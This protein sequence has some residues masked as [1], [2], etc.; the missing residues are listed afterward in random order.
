[1]EALRKHLKATLKSEEEFLAG[2]DAG[3]R[4]SARDAARPGT[5]PP[6][7]Q[8]LRQARVASHPVE[9]VRH[10]FIKLLPVVVRADLVESAAW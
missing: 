8:Q 10:I 9:T 7:E 3:E 6:Q 5:P 2:A 4:Q 1:M